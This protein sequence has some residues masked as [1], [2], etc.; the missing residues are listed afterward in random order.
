MYLVALVLI[1]FALIIIGIVYWSSLNL[2]SEVSSLVQS[3]RS[4]SSFPIEQL[5]DIKVINDIITNE[6]QLHRLLMIEIIGKEKDIK[7]PPL[8]LENTEIPSPNTERVLASPITY[9]N[10]SNN[11]DI[12]GKILI[13]TFGGSLTQRI[14]SLM[15]QR[16]NI[17]KEYYESM[18]NIICHDGSCLHINS[19]QSPSDILNLQES[20]ITYYITP[21]TPTDSFPSSNIIR[22]LLNNNE[23][24]EHDCE[25]LLAG[26]TPISAPDI[27]SIT[28]RNLNFITKEL[29]DTITTVIN[30]KD[31]DQ[32]TSSLEQT[33]TM[34]HH[35]YISHGR[36]FNLFILYNKELINQAKSYAQKQYD[37]SMNCSQSL[38]K[39]AHH[40][41]TEFI[42]IYNLATT[43]I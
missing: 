40:I 2:S 12:L 18:N 24:S 4:P 3:S 22:S 28:L 25:I 36:L 10:I 27:T 17:I 5:S 21:L 26:G 16:I 29:V 32:T 42:N 37:T 7:I 34:K 19:Q 20:K 9:K 39:I 33:S 14:I 6:S 31:V 1:F 11:I 35:K 30:I 15:H 41:S 8:S 43:N 23:I 38:S 13:K